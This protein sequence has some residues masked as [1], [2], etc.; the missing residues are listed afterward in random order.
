MFFFV[1]YAFLIWYW[2]VRWRRRWP[3]FASVA[4]GACG[5]ALVGFFHYRLNVWTGGK[6]FLPVLQSI[7]YPYG[8]MVVAVGMYISCLPARR[9]EVHCRRCHYDLEGLHED[10]IDSPRCPECGLEEA[11]G[12]P[13]RNPP[14]ADRQR[15][16]A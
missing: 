16:M 3:A 9:P 10:E 2:C 11:T 12:R 1:A 7:L 14:K 5:V 8:V 6:I 4:A 13:G 15:A